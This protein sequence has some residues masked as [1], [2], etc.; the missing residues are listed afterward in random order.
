MRPP[1]LPYIDALRGVAVILMILLHAADGWLKPGLK[2]GIG[3]MA[4]RTL[5]G[6]A[7]P[8]FLLLA[9]VGVGIGWAGRAEDDPDLRARARQ[10]LWSRGLEIVL[11]GYALRLAMWWV[12]SGTIVRLPGLVG[13][14]ILAAGYYALWQALP[15]RRQGRPV[16]WLGGGAACC[17][18]ALLYLATR[19]P[20]AHYTL[21]R[22]DVLQTIGAAM[23]II[24]ALEPL[25]RARSYL[26][27]ALGLF[28]TLLTPSISSLLPG[29]LPAAIAG[30]IGPYQAVP[31][32]A[33]SGR[34]PLFPWLA[35]A[36]VGTAFGHALGRGAQRSMNAAGERAAIELAVLGAALALLC[37]ESVPETASLLVR[38]PWLTPTVRVLYRIGLSMVLAALCIGLASPRM[39]GQ[40]SLLALGRASL[41]VYC[42]HL[43]FAF[44]LAAEPVRKILDYPAFLVGTTLLVGAM[45][46]FAHLWLGQKDRLRLPA[47]PVVSQ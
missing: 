19:E 16:L 28:V 2:D 6:Q 29:E 14:G 33:P 5:G 20:R 38:E 3:W 1:R 39:P 41:A 12:D 47:R 45:T 24:A 7:A 34:F 11:A 15:H 35:H 9:G 43:E 17:A 4:I 31:G 22:P 40:R 18:V 42:V 46:V 25:L 8:L 21:L 36:L 32:G 27:C 13:G 10:T 44:G 37:C 30:Y 23:V 26:A